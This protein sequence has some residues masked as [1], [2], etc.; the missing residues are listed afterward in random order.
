VADRS[1]LLLHQREQRRACSG[2]RS[3]TVPLAC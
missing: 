3:A 1:V 2:P